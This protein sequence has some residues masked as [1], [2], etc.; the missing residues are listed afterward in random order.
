MGLLSTIL[1]LFG[2]GTEKSS[3]SQ[4]NNSYKLV[5]DKITIQEL[6]KEL[7]KL[8]KGKTE[9]DFTGITSNGTDCIYFMKDG[10]N[11][12]IDFEA[13]GEDQLKYIEKLK[14]FSVSKGYKFEMTTYGNKPEYNSL[15]NAPVIQIKTN[16]DLKTTAEI[17]KII[18]ESIFH[19][20]ID[21]IYEVV[22]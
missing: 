15:T 22:P 6:P 4:P 16:S 7:E 11:F 9:Y 21:T 17:G 5:A 10:T 1:S 3:N 2:C 14:E 18:Q 8:Q 12:Q 20:N 19:N 13:M